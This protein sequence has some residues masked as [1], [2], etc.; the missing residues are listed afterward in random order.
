MK[1]KNNI[2]IRHQYRY[3]RIMMK[4]R[5]SANKQTKETTHPNVSGKPKYNLREKRKSSK[6]N[7]THS[8]ILRSMS[9]SY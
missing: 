7:R 1:L 2:N 8:M 3:T 6:Q 9:K 5:S 4:L